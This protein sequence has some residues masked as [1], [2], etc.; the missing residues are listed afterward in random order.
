MVLLHT[1]DIL[2]IYL[3]ERRSLLETEWLDYASGEPL[4]Q[5]LTLALRLARENRVLGL[6]T[7]QQGMRTISPADQQWIHDNFLPALVGLPLRRFGVVVSRDPLNR[8]AMKTIAEHMTVD[9]PAEVQT[10]ETPE[11]ARRWVA[12]A[13]PTS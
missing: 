7:N 2:R 3:D 4:R 11:Q 9:F 5:S 13:P 8:M 12:P 1:S 10:F 6:V